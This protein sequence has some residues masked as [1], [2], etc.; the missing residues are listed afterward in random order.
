VKE[1]K[2]LADFFVFGVIGAQL[3]DHHHAAKHQQGQEKQ[4]ELVLLHETHASL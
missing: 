2:C 3:P 4:N 1:D